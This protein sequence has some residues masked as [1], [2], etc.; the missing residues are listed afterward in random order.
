M[1][2]YA[3]LQAHPSERNQGL[4][5]SIKERRVWGLGFRGTGFRVQGFWVYGLGFRI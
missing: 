1:Q 4:V 3:K 2:H 5:F